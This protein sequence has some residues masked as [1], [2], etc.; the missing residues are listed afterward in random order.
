LKNW[1]SEALIAPSVSS[2]VSSPVPTATRR[3]ENAPMT[4]VVELEGCQLLLESVRALWAGLDHLGLGPADAA[5]RA[6]R[7]A[8]HSAEADTLRLAAL[9]RAARPHVGDA[10]PISVTEIAAGE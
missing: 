2:R 8:N 6:Q 3:V 10:G 9:E 1:Q 7:A 4:S 5:I